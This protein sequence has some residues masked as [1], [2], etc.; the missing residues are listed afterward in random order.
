MGKVFLWMGVV[1]LAIYLVK[2]QY[3]SSKTWGPFRDGCLASGGATEEQCSCLSD[4]VHERFSDQ[5]VQRIMDTR[6]TD[7][8]FAEKVNKTVVA[9]TLACRNP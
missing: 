9:G 4:Y 3:L 8:V 1:L 7:P 5:E 2:S 6:I